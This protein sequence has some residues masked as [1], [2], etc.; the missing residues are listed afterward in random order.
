MRKMYERI[1]ASLLA[2]MMLFCS[3]VQVLA[4]TP[5]SSFGST[6]PSIKPG[7]SGYLNNPDPIFRDYGFRI[8]LTTSA[9]MG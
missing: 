9:P 5:G 4:E 2:V 8:T 7:G 6:I 3:P 1:V